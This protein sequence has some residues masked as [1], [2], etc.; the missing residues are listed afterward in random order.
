MSRW[1]QLLQSLVARFNDA[2]IWRGGSRVWN[3]RMRA[4]TFERRL[5]LALHRFGWMGASE[6]KT[7]SRLARPGAT[8]IDVGAN[9]GLYTVLLSKLTGEQGQVIA[10]EPDPALFRQLQENCVLNGCANVRAFNSAVGRQADR[11]HLQ[12]LVAN[13]GDNHLSREPSKFFRQTIAVDVVKLDDVLR[14]VRPDLLKIDVQGWEYEVLQGADQLLAANPH[15]EL[16]LELWPAGL[17]RAGST[18]TDLIQWLQAR[19]FELYLAESMKR[20]DESALASLANEIRGL[21]HVDLFAT[22][23]SASVAT[24]ASSPDALPTPAQRT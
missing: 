1:S 2:R 22:R 5:Y 9:L 23:K 19:N 12:K 21:N 16:Y 20:L 10:F 15:A 11:L 7:I 6:R 13:T 8:I 18:V 3:Q 14:D 24:P 4:T 17:T